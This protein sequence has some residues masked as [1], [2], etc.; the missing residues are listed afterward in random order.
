[1]KP[2]EI[3]QQQCG[4][5]YINREIYEWIDCFQNG[6]IFICDQECSL[7]LNFSNDL[8]T[9]RFYR[10]NLDNIIVTILLLHFE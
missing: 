10:D 9:R 5:N 4:E 7:E 1:M 8:S 3:I 2:T 6:G